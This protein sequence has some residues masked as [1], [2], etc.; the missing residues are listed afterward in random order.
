MCRASQRPNRLRVGGNRSGDVAECSVDVGGKCLH[1]GS[2]SEG[3]QSDDQRV[4]DQILTFFLH[5]TLDRNAELGNGV[6]SVCSPRGVVY[7]AFGWV[8]PLYSKRHAKLISLSRLYESATYSR[9]DRGNREHPFTAA[10]QQIRLVYM[11]RKCQDDETKAVLTVQG[12]DACALM[13]GLPVTFAD[14]RFNSPSDAL[15]CR[16]L[17][18]RW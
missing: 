8:R 17:S 1:A 12:P 9:D 3:D 4:L 14:Q 18:S 2:C 15:N 6:H 16:F 5:Q 11:T 7:P 10:S 13:E